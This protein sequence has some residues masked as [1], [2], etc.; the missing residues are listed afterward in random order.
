M[1]QAVIVGGTYATGREVTEFFL[2]LGP[3]SGLIGLMI[4]MVCFSLSCM[5][6]FELARRYQ[7]LDYKSFCRVYMGRFWFLYEIGFLFGVMLTLSVIGAAASEIAY[8]MVGAPKLGSALAFMGLVAGLVYTGG[9]RLEKIISLWSI[10]FYVVYILLA[11]LIYQNFGEEMLQNI[12]ATPVKLADTTASALIYT[13]FSCAILP[14]LVFVARNFRAPKEALIS[15][16]LAGPLVILPGVAIILML[17]PFYPAVI[18]QP[19]PISLVLKNVGNPVFVWFVQIAI[20][21]ALASTGAGLLHGVNERVAKSMED[22]KRKMPAVLRPC[23]ALSAMLFSVFLAT[24]VGIVD[25]VAIGFRY[26]A[27]AFIVVIFLPLL[28]RGVWMVLRSN[29][30]SN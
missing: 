23:L 30:T 8:E 22:S 24:E 26:S 15:G 17:I 28:T 18:E 6:V 3:L 25:L 1:I 27:Y 16:A 9:S 7:V 12:S 11:I 20:L 21:G 10:Y 2:K 4:T 5:L 19:L 14:T 29:D 13:S